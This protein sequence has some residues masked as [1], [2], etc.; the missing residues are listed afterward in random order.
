LF[1][2]DLFTWFSGR[3]IFW[4]LAVIML[5]MGLTLTADDFR[6]VARMPK[7]V[8]LGFAAQFTIMPLLGWSIGRAFDLATPFAVGLVLVSC[9]P[10][11]T[12]SNVV[13]Y[14][15]RANVCLSVVMTMCSTLAAA[16][17]TPG[18][19]RALAGTRVPVD[20]LGL[21]L[22]TCQ[23]ILLPVVL[24]A[25]INRFAPRAVE[26]VK[27]GLPLV[28]V[29]VIALICA[30]IIG[31]NAGAVKDSALRLLG[32]VFALHVGGFGIGYAVARLFRQNV[33]TARTVSIEVGM[34]NS[35]LGTVLAQRHFADPLTAVPCAI[36]AVFHSVIGSVL[37]GWWRWRAEERPAPEVAPAGCAAS[38][39]E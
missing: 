19:T 32:A 31:A 26:K 25:L 36:S 23:V 5:G 13:A 34:Q 8:A 3:W 20:V 28:S 29:L 35:G 11:G 14:L 24:G 22:S 38:R 37:A 18:L 10:G 16:V 7:A 1:E 15:A 4:G 12:A 21:F 30:S 27:H 9:C 17:M 6:G 39:T 33:I 2:P